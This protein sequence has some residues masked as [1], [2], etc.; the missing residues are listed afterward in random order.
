MFSLFP[1][2][3][4]THFWQASETSGIY[5]VV[6]TNKFHRV[7]VDL[8]TNTS[9]CL[10]TPCWFQIAKQQARLYSKV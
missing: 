7:S 10:L 6:S 5:S 8:F 1:R 2:H 4:L 3:R 9:I